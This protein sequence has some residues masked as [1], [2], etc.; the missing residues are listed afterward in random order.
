M[1]E[2][3]TQ[4]III[5]TDGHESYKYNIDTWETKTIDFSI[6]QIYLK[7]GCRLVELGSKSEV[8]NWTNRFMKCPIPDEENWNFFAKEK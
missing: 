1:R 7:A 6:S 3:I 4:E 8:I 2:T 5:L